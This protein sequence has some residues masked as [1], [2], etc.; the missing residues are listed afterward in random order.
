MTDQE[1]PATP[2]RPAAYRALADALR[3]DIAAGVYSE[4]GKMPTEEALQTTYKVSRHTVRQALQTLLSEGR[5]YRV[6][7]SGTYVSGRRLSGRYMRSIGSLDDIVVWPDTE[8]EVLQ[9]F[10]T[11]ADPAIATRL[12]LTYIEV[13]MALVRR[14]IKGVP[15]VVT[16]HYVA[17]DLGETL[18]GNGIPARGEGTVIGSAEPFLKHPV[19]G[20]R[21]DITA[22]NAP[23]EEAGLIGCEPGD[24]ILL[25]ERLYYD[26]AGS[27]V[28]FTT[29]HFN[30]RRYGYRM[31]LRRSH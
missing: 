9:Q 16:R 25:I 27:Y 24:A 13:S 19:A 22:M 11:R 6:Q 18:R 30:P 14:F 20:V 28:E 8:T 31:E 5:I 10:A 26:T 2:R 12:E 29:S 4:G 21:Q 23:E 15:F 7:G 3:A 1:R 17:P